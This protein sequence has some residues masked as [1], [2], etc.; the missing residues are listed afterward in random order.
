MLLVNFKL[1]KPITLIKENGVISTN[2]EVRDNGEVFIKEPLDYAK[3]SIHRL[4]IKISVISNF[5][6]H[7]YFEDKLCISEIKSVELNTTG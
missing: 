5:I 7:I 4:N 2:F 3:R 6:F 1:K